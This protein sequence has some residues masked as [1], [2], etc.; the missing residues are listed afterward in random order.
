MEPMDRNS[1]RLFQLLQSF[2]HQQVPCDLLIRACEPRPTW[3]S[4]GEIVDRLPL[5]AGVPQWLVEFYYDNKS[6]FDTTGMESQSG[7]IESTLENNGVAYLQVISEEQHDLETVDER[8]LAR[9]RIAVMLQA[10]PSVNAEIIGEEIVDRFMD[11]VKTSI[12]P[13]LSSLT[14]ADIEDWLLPEIREE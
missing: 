5:E 9:D 6:L 1:A 8:I 2:Q 3:S 12:L 14:V 7:Y 13:L 10:F 4:T 11:I